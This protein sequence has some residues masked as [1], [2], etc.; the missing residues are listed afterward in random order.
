MHAFGFMNISELFIAVLKKSI[1]FVENFSALHGFNTFGSYQGHLMSQLS[2]N[3]HH[4]SNK[5]RSIF[6]AE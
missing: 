2:T 1:E 5:F 6:I 3:P 4:S